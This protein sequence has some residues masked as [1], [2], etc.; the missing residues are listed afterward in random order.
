[1]TASAA[2]ASWCVRK[3]GEGR[4]RSTSGA[5]PVN[6]VRVPWGDVFSAYFSTGIPDIEDYV[7]APPALQRQL[8]IGRMIAPLTTF[9]PIRNLLL[10][11]VRPGR[12]QSF[13]RG[14]ERTSGPKSPASSFTPAE[15]TQGC[16]SK[17]SPICGAASNRW[18][19]GH[20]R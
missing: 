5:G 20:R 11:A 17:F 4:S 1:M 2:T 14:P 7:A 6:A 13:V 18:P 8:A 15:W 12:A 10:M 9:A 16:L 3:P 19:V